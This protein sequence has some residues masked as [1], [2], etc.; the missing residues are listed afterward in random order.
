MKINQCEKKIS[1]NDIEKMQMN[2]TFCV[3]KKMQIT[4]V[5]FFVETVIIDENEKKMNH[6]IFSKIRKL[7]FFLNRN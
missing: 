7:K 4:I 3:E 1:E 5:F 6:A 2:E